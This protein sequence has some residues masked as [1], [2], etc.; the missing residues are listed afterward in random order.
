MTKHPDTMT[1][2]EFRRQFCKDGGVKLVSSKVVVDKPKRGKYN[3]VKVERDGHKFDSKKEADRYDVLKMEYFSGAISELRLQ[4][5]NPIVVN[6]VKVCIYKSD[7][8]YIR[9]GVKITEDVKSDMTRKLP[10]YR[11]KKK[12]MKACY[13]V[14]ILET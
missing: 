10:T 3:N 13:G 6:G 2:A 14:D 9:D 11:L 12:L 7:F 1:S 8:E 5:N 4:V